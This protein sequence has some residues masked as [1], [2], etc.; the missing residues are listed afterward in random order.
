MSRFFIL[1]LSVFL[2]TALKCDST[3]LLKSF[4]KFF[5]LYMMLKKRIISRRLIDLQLNIVKLIE[6]NTRRFL[7]KIHLNIFIFIITFV[8]YI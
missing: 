4:M 3:Q 7:T 6:I 1:F 2:I 5:I 8:T